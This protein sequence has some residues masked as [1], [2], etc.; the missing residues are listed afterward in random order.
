MSTRKVGDR[1]EDWVCKR[2]EKDGFR[3][4]KINFYSHF[5]EI[6]IVGI[7]DFCLVNRMKR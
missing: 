7:D 3:V 2:L 6:D 5:G 4:L 1:Y